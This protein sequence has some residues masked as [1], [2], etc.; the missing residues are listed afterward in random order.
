LPESDPRLA[1]LVG[2]LTLALSDA[3]RDATETAAD[4]AAAGPS[5]LIALNEFLAQPSIDEMRRVVGLT[6]S[7]A[8]RLVDRLEAQGYVTRRPGRDARAVSVVLTA[9]G[10][11]A[12]E[13]VR[14]ARASAFD[15][16][17]AVLSSEEQRSLAGLTEKLLAAITDQRLRDRAREKTPPGGWLCRL[18]DFEACGRPRGDCPVASTAARSTA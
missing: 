18:C 6:H 17:L 16:V 11:R 5:T 4:H 3:M 1:N 10:K 7:G 8:V 12:A 14:V 9:K 2:A 15:S 13:R